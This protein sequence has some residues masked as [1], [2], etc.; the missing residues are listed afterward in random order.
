M[1]T[2]Y[3][4]TYDGLSPLGGHHVDH[5]REDGETGATVGTVDVSNTTHTNAGIC[6]ADSWSFTGDDE[7]QQ[8]GGTVDDS[9]AR[10]TRRSLGDRHTT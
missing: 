10:S 1:V 8:P 2:P 4:V 9:T 5:G 7:L 6:H 3:T